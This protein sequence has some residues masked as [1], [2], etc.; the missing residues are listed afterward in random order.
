MEIPPAAKGN[1]RLI[2]PGRTRQEGERTRK[3]QSWVYLRVLLLRA[4]TD[5]DRGT[6]CSELLGSRDWCF[7][8]CWHWNSGESAQNHGL[9]TLKHFW[10]HGQGTFPSPSLALGSD[11]M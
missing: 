9:V 4:A 10:F 8:V 11:G 3:K 1:S 7:G 2:N 6:K 5:G